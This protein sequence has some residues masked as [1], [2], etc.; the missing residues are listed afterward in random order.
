MIVL[1]RVTLPSAGLYPVASVAFAGIAYGG[2]DTLHGSG[3]LAVFL[4]GLVIGSA[5]SPA[6]RTIVTFHEGLAW[7]A[8]LAL[9][10]L[11]GLLVNPG[12]LIEI[13]PEGAAIAVVT[14]V[15][16]RPLAALLVAHGFT[17]PERLM[18]G[19]AGP[20]RRDADRVRHLPGHRGHRRTADL[21]FKVAFFVVLLSTVLQ[22][23]TI[24]PVAR[25]LRRRL[26]RGGDP[27]A[28]GRAG[29]AEPAGR[30]DD[31]VPG[32]RRRRDRRAIRCASSGCRA[33][34]C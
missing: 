21:I 20:A 22:G 25:W 18:L 14:A 34:R 1:Q 2:A 8:Q 12:E 6:R 5:S 23:L 28:A 29:A 17:L 26:R 31:A 16:A 30:R 3:F 13:I 7:V 15:V 24:E 33:R 32:A 19:W 11:L 9:F 27:R 4:A 10:L